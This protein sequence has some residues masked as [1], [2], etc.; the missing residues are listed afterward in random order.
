MNLRVFQ[1]QW[2]SFS[3]AL[4]ARRDVE[5]AGIILAERLQGGG[6]LLARHFVLIPDDGYKIRRIDQIRIDPIALNRLIRR[7]RDEGLSIITTHTH[8]NTN[9]AWFSTAD[10]DG[11]SRLMPSFLVQTPGP[12]GSIVIAGTS[13][14]A[15]G[16]VW[17]EPGAKA[18]LRISVVGRKLRVHSVNTHGPADTR[19]FDRQQLALGDAGQ[20][21][22]RDLHVAV[23]GLGGTGSVSFAQLA[24]LGVGRI[25][26]VDGDLIEDCNVSRIIGSSSRDAGITYK[27]D[28]AA[29]YAETLGLGTR[30]RTLRGRLGREVYVAAIEDCDIILSCVDRH[31]PRAILNRLAYS[32]AIP[33]IDMGSAFRVDVSG[34]VVAGAGRVVLVG[35]GYR[36][37]GCWGHI[38]PHRLRI[39]ALSEADRARETA[40]GYIDGADVAQPSVVA[41]NT[42]I[43]GAAV[44]EFLRLVTGFAGAD[45][46]P[47]R[48]SFDFEAGTVQRNRLAGGRPCAICCVGIATEE[49]S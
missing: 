28:A 21:V 40:D 43:A 45:D 22:L 44:V 10:D 49:R 11:D 19:W 20:T 1:D 37:L 38:D 32:K 4:R 42:M 7:A 47:E 8:P 13:G 25:T 17:S 12:H 26:A 36:C 30:V 35:P 3:N 6:V 5:T 48:L 2:E 34:R 33:I 27:V 46:P 39:E 14:L 31:A 41:F 24:H 18:D 9:Q 29:R 23:V 15:V 16:R